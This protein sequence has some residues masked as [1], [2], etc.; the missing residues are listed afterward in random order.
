MGGVEEKFTEFVGGELSYNRM[1]CTSCI[2][3]CAKVMVP[4]AIEMNYINYSSI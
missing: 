2:V 4:K 3:Q 1:T